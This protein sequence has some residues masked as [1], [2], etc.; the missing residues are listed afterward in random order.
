MKKIEEELYQK[1]MSMLKEL[2]VNILLVE[3]FEKMPGYVKFMKDLVNNKWMVS[4]EPV[5]NMNHCSA[6]AS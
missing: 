5:D 1:F 6:I 2:S 4:F 3:S